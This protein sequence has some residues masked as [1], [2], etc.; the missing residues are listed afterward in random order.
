VDGFAV[1]GALLGRGGQRSELLKVRVLGAEE[2]VEA[3]LPKVPLRTT[4]AGTT[5]V[6]GWRLSA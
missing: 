6:S 5:T 4:R 2:V 3:N 1:D